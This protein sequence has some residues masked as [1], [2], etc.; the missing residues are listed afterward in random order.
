MAT[1]LLT[2]PHGDIGLLDWGAHERAVQSGYRCTMEYFGQRRT[3]DQERAQD[4]A[5]S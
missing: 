2:P 5:G 3:K 1:H 4:S